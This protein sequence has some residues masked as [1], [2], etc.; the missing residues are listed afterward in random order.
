LVAEKIGSTLLQQKR[1]KPG[2]TDLA[3]RKSAADGAL[4]ESYR[5]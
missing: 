4:A 1:I 5:G 2:P 3:W